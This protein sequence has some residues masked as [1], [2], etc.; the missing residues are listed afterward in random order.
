VIPGKPGRCEQFGMTW[1]HLVKGG[2]GGEQ[3]QLLDRQPRHALRVGPA[4]G[5]ANERHRLSCTGQSLGLLNQ[6]LQDGQCRLRLT[7]ERPQHIEAHHIARA[8]PDRIDRGFPVMPRQN[9]LLHIAVA[10]EAFHRLVEKTRRA[11]ADP[12]FDRGRQK[13]HVGRFARIVRRLVERT[14]Q[15]H[16]Q[17]DRGFDMQ[18]HV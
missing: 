15:P 3:R 10:A 7:R 13:P 9:A 16:H 14:A 4:E 18:R 1:R 6:A 8:F 17:R 2:H 11:L 5:L 12:V